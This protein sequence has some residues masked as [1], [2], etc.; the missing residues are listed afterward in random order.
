MLEAHSLLLVLLAIYVVSETSVTECS[1][2]IRI[3]T[4]VAGKSLPS[5]IRMSLV[6]SRHANSCIEQK[7]ALMFFAA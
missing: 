5:V 3:T 4:C 6:F 1:P 2:L 7:C